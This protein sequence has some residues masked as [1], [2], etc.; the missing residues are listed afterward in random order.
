MRLGLSR[1]VAET[2]CRL[3][4]K[5]PPEPRCLLGPNSC[6]IAACERF[7]FSTHPGLLPFAMHQA[8]EEK[9]QGIDS[10]PWQSRCITT[11]QLQ[12]RLPLV[13]LYV[14]PARL[15]SHSQGGFRR[16]LPSLMSHLW[17]LKPAGASSQSLASSPA[18][19]HCCLSPRGCG[20]R[21]AQ[22]WARSWAL[23]GGSWGSASAWDPGAASMAEDHFHS[24]PLL[25]DLSVTARLV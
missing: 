5:R 18:S 14:H 12:P 3:P 23:L 22:P 20:S 13:T 10:P 8:A 7:R 17:P 4:C 1:D 15:L 24:R 19:S 21:S 16:R 6:Q 9:K 11:A 2:R 25:A